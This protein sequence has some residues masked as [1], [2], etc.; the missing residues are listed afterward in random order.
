MPSG[1]TNRVRTVGKV[2][3]STPWRDALHRV[4]AAPP[5][6]QPENVDTGA[7][8]RDMP[9]VWRDLARHGATWRD[10]ARSL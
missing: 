3:I 9:A 8:W 2:P 5:W 6:G 1:T 7:T 4:L 10:P